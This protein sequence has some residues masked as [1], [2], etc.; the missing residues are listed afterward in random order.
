[1]N[2]IERGYLIAEVADEAK[3]LSLDPDLTPHLAP[4]R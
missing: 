4:A 1:M 2:I 3:E